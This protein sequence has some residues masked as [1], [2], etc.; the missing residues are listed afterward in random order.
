MISNFNAPF[1]GWVSPETLPT[2]HH[3]VV[4]LLY[5]KEFEMYDISLGYYE[6]KKW[7]HNKKENFIVRGW[8]PIPFIPPAWV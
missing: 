7:W 2:T 5:D 4:I 6:D 8:V 1:Y 3:Y